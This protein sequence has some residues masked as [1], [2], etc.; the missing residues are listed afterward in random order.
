M[1]IVQIGTGVA[2]IPPTGYGGIERTIAELTAALRA[3]G[4]EVSVV[5][6]LYRGRPRD[7][8]RFAARLKGE[9]GRGPAD[10]V[11]AHLAAP[12]V[13]LAL[14]GIPYVYTSHHLRWTSPEGAIGRIRSSLERTAVGKAGQVLALSENAEASIHRAFP[15][16]R[17]HVVPLGVDAS[18][19]SGPERDPP[20]VALGVG[21]VIP[22]KRWELAVEAFR[23]TGTRLRVVG[24]LA[25]AAYAD[26]LRALGS[27]ELA[28]PVSDERLREEYR[29]ARFLVH[30]SAAEVFPGVVLQ[31]LSVGLPVVGAAA[32]APPVVDGANG[33]AIASRTR[34]ELVQRLRER[35]EE[36]VA[37]RALWRRLS[38]NARATAT[39]RYGWPAIV[40]AHESVYARQLALFGRALPQ[41]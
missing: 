40:A 11:H 18:F 20:A 24:P 26:R 5:N 6:P 2:P 10:V 41:P 21:A 15:R 22:R 3:A 19:W 8:F 37:D 1:R 39:E 27:V 13:R 36:L 16:Q 28:G 30:P 31:A 29:G 38:A 7:Q 32:V 17:V 34:A 12:A 33:Y 9:L 25:D 23:G 14:L 35:G 4:H